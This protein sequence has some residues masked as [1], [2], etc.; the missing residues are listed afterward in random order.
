MTVFETE[1]DL[2]REAAVAKRIGP[3]LGVS[4][5]KCKKL[6][7]ADYF[8]LDQNGEVTG[9]MEIRT[10]N[11]TAEQLNG[12]GGVFLPVD[13]LAAIYKAGANL[14]LDFYFV[15]KTTNCLLHLCFKSG[16]TWPRLEQT[17]GGRSNE[18]LRAVE[19][20]GPVYLFPTTLFT[21]IDHDPA[22]LPTGSP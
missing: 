6:S 9:I 4:L 10:R 7:H 12:W 22:P 2:T 3:I 5:I 19:D 20:V 18:T 17:I 16:T 13:K 21:R 14:N 11:Y 8:V 1:A 15:V